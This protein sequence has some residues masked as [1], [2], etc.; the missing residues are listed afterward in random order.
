ME[1]FRNFVIR[2]KEELEVQADRVFNMDEV[3]MSFD[4]PYT[5]IVDT[6]GAESI[7]ISTT[8]HERTG[9]TVVLSCS[10]SG[11]KLKPMVIFKRATT[12]KER[13]PDGVVHCHKKGWMDRVGMVV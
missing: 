10:E 9:F 6:T 1:S 13:I 3:P 4:A 8:G 7:P 12:P 5:R 11:K 2:R